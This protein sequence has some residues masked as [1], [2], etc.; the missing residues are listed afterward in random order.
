MHPV[1]KR[2]AIH[3]AH[4]HAQLAVIHT[5]ADG[6]A[7]AQVLPIDLA[8]QRQVLALGE[9]KLLAQFIGHIETHNGSLGR[10]RLHRAH[11]QGVKQGTHGLLSLA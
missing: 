10:I 11:R 9:G 2:T 3:T 1:R 5:R 4:A 6:V 8:A 7:A